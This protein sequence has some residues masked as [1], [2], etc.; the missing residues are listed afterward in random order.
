VAAAV[1]IA[2]TVFVAIKRRSATIVRRASVPQPA[3]DRKFDTIDAGVYYEKS[4]IRTESRG[5]SLPG[6]PSGATAHVTEAAAFE[7]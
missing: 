7:I 5:S 4:P 2:I 3:A 6:T 1:L